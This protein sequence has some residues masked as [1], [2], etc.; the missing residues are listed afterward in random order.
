M[1]ALGFFVFVSTLLG[2]TGCERPTANG[3]ENLADAHTIL[4]IEFTNSDWINDSL[5]LIPDLSQ[6][7]SLST[8][9]KKV[10]TSLLKS[11]YGSKLKG[12][13]EVSYSRRIPPLDNVS[14][15]VFEFKNSNDPKTFTQERLGD[16]I[17]DYEITE[18]N[19]GVITMINDRTGKVI[20]LADVYYVAVFRLGNNTNNPELANRFILKLN[21]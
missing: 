16:A 21:D 13:Y 6:F 3:I 14:V 20:K 17:D 2:A 18:S 5:V 1:R 9:N 11:K 4:M 19:D 10:A 15:R 8:Q 12:A 7:D